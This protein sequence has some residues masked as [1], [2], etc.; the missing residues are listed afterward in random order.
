MRSVSKALAAAL[1]LG[2]ATLAGGRAEAQSPLD[3]SVVYNYGEMETTRSLALGGGLRAL[4]D[5]TTAIYMNPAAMAE[6]RVYHLEAFTQIAPETRRYL[7]GGT[8]VDSV[9]GRLSGALAVNGGWMDDKGIDRSMIDVRLALAYLVTDRFMLGLGGRYIKVSQGGVGPFGDDDKVAGGLRSIED[10]KTSRA[11]FVN[12]VT[13][14]AGLV[15]RITDAIY[16][17]IAGQNLTYPKNSLVPTLVGGGLGFTTGNLSVEVDGLADLNS[18]GTP[19]ARVGGGGEY[20]IAERFPVRLGV[21]YD[22]GAKLA[23]LSGGFG[24]VGSEFAIEGAVKRTL[25]NPGVT[26]MVF[27]IA[28]F[29][30]SSGLTRPAMPEG[31]P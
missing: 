31:G 23:T 17:G 3:P 30:E 5:G 20:R 12:T 28:Y 25:S 8:V 27:S 18:W 22:Q 19:T 16:L 21:R 14:D 7:F 26:T 13:F 4:G 2:L 1:T 11:A 15:V 29:L 6:R 10:G 9:T 24:Y